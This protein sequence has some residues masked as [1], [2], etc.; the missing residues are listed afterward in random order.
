LQGN[1]EFAVI[2]KEDILHRT[3]GGLDLVEHIYRCKGLEFH[4]LRKHNKN[5]YYND[6]RPSVV[7]DYSRQGVIVFKDFGN[8]AYRG[9][10]FEFA[11]HYYG[12]DT[13]NDFYGLLKAIASD[14]RLGLDL[15]QPKQPY[16]ITSFK[17]KNTITNQ[18]SVQK[19][20]GKV[21]KGN[22]TK[23]WISYKPM[24]SYN[25]PPL[26][27]GYKSEEMMLHSL[28][29][30]L[31]GNRIYSLVFCQL[32]DGYRRKENFVKSNLVALDFDCVPLMDFFD[33]LSALNSDPRCVLAYETKRSCNGYNYNQE[34]EDNNSYVDSANEHIN[35]DEII[36]RIRALFSL[37]IEVDNFELLS[38]LIKRLYDAYI[39]YNPDKQATNPTQAF[40]TGN[41]EV[42]VLVE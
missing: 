3:N 13:K 32:K 31:Q 10:V 40:F 2:S 30:L 24:N 37:G 16:S 19:L 25:E 36:V 5:P 39:K 38:R 22:N 33:L 14:L 35:A 21:C 41:R 4:G 18:V 42:Y 26:A 23:Y 6:T 7:F 27:D 8:E 12:F 9:D 29:S 17:R 20:T 34:V 1:S 15:Q 28:L 11:K